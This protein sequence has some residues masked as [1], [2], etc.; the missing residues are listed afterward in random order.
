MFTDTRFPKEGSMAKKTKEQLEAELAPIRAELNKLRDAEI[1]A[2]SK[3][4]VGK[5]FKYRNCYSCPKGPSDYWWLYVKV[6]GVGDY[7]PIA[8]EFQ[9]DKDGRSEVK[10]NECFSCHEG[11]REISAKEFNAAWRKFKNEIADIQP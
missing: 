1:L 10:R 3:A 9:T 5:C 2:K 7:W 8:L 4:L 6:I 11:H